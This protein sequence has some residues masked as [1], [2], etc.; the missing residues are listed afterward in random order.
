MLRGS[1]RRSSPEAA[2]RASITQRRSKAAGIGSSE[3][4][5]G[6][7]A[8]F[9]VSF[10]NNADQPSFAAVDVIGRL[11]SDGTVTVTALQG[12][13]EGSY[14]ERRRRLR[15]TQT[16]DMVL[17]HIGRRRSLWGGS[18]KVGWMYETGSAH[19]PGCVQCQ[20]TCVFPRQPRDG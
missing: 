7:I 17:A 16:I 10:Q 4:V 15:L 14:S 2:S 19:A 6:H 12:I 9:D 3:V 8:R 1:V 18:C 11:E 13:D 5:L 20:W